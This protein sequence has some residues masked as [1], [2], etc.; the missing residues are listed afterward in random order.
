MSIDRIIASSAS[1]ALVAGLT[2]RPV[3]GGK[4]TRK[5]LDEAR[6]QLDATHYVLQIGPHAASYGFFV[7][8]LSE[9]GQKLPKGAT[10]AAAVFA[11][12]VGTETPNAALL[13]S[14]GE[15]D[16][17]FLVTLDDGV[18]TLDMVS[19]R[20]AV[21]DA[22]GDEPRPVWTDQ[23][24]ISDHEVRDAV[25]LQWLMEL[26]NGK[27]SR[28]LPVP[29][30]VLPAI[31]ITIAIVAVVGGWYGWSQHKK[32]QARKLAEQEAM[33]ADPVP[34]YM[35]A[36]ASK[37]SL[38]FSDRAGLQRLVTSLLGMPAKVLRTGSVAPVWQLMMVECRTET[39]ACDAT[40]LRKGGTFEELKAAFPST[41]QVV[42]V[43]NGSSPSLDLAVLRFPMTWA[44]STAAAP[45]LLPF[46]RAF[47]EGGSVLQFWKNAGMSPEIKTPVLWPVAAGVPTSF[48]TPNGVMQGEI[49]VT[50]VPGTFVGEV[51]KGAPAWMSWEYMR[52][53]IPSNTVAPASIVQFTLTAKYYVASK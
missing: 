15:G 43:K 12:A 38:M 39:A 46:D 30:N 25:D 53:E 45:Q 26:P 29:V 9:E 21:L 3:T 47:R 50:G 35:A 2:W 11:N 28:L 23:A 5:R 4:H 49:T 41:P 1:G 17:F 7:A 10:S 19:D 20:H 31:L 48:T 18:P 52:L 6:S 34:K 16:R 8:R 37:R 51:L 36:L 32:A 27:T 42:E 13:L 22:L 33:D 24:E 44:R 14:L 40:W